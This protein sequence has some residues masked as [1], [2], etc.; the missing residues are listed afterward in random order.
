[1]RVK[2]IGSVKKGQFKRKL[3]ELGYRIKYAASETVGSVNA[4]KFLMY[5]KA[6][7]PEFL[8][9]EESTGSIEV[10][11]LSH[12]PNEEVLSAFLSYGPITFPPVGARTTIINEEGVTAI[13]DTGPPEKALKR[14]IDSARRVEA[15]GDIDEQWSRIG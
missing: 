9:F 13:D 15:I 7:N 4:P 5:E 2:L 3:E 8:V 14:F 12:Q 1:M 11:F 6:D 10:C